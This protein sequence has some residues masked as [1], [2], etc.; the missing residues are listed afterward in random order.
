LAEFSFDPDDYDR[1]DEYDFRRDERR[2]QDRLD[3]MMREQFEDDFRRDAQ[4]DRE[5]EAVRE[6]VNN[7]TIVFTPAQ[8][9][10]INDPSMKMDRTGT[11]RKV[12]RRAAPKPAKPSGRQ[13]IRGSG[14]FMNRGIPLKRTR[15]KTKMDKTMSKCLKIAN[16]K[17]RKANGQ[18]RKGKTMRD[19]MRHA[20]RLCK[21][22]S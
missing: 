22:E 11:V 13:V 12:G 21:K 18:L 5:Q 10:A 3:E 8:V 16:K 4:R 20:H 17:F 14:Q 1:R 15:K 19:V 2:E 9:K 6:V 7:D